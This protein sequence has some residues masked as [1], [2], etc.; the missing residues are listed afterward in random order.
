MPA[1]CGRDFLNISGTRARGRKRPTGARRHVRQ[2]TSSASSRRDRRSAETEARA[3]AYRPDA[4]LFQQI[5][6]M[7]RLL[8]APGRPAGEQRRIPFPVRPATLHRAAGRTTGGRLQ[9]SG[10]AGRGGLLLALCHRVTGRPSD[11]ERDNRSCQRKFRHCFLHDSAPPE[12]CDRS[13]IG[14]LYARRRAAPRRDLQIARS[15]SRFC[16]TCHERDVN[17]FPRAVA[18]G[19]RRHR[20][21]KACNQGQRDRG[22][23]GSVMVGATGIEPVTPTMSR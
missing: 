4:G 9:S 19:R 3:G 5:R 17:E 10:R 1:T 20:S 6:L 2:S 15:P 22:R 8:R 21:R 16:V 23:S 12:K 14:Q 18:P 11:R 13:A 7:V